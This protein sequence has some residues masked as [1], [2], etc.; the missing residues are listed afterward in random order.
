VKEVRDGLRGRKFCGNCAVLEREKA[1]E[2]N[3]WPTPSH[4]MCGLGP[5]Q[6]S[7]QMCIA[8]PPQDGHRAAIVRSC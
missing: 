1:A 6:L 3:P 8:P 7:E 4:G 2:S 5:I